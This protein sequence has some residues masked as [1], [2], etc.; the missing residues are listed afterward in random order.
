MT[1]DERRNSPLQRHP[2]PIPPTT[3]PASSIPTGWREHGRIEQAE[4][5]RVQLRLA[6][7]DA[8]ARRT[9]KHL[10]LRQQALLR[11]HGDAWLAP[12]RPYLHRTFDPPLRPE[13]RVSPSSARAS[14]RRPFVE[15][16]RFLADPAGLFAAAPNHRIRLLDLLFRAAQ[17][18]HLRRPA[19]RRARVVPEFP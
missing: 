8:L 17:S 4:F 5:I 14:S 18:P 10:E 6:G 3:R 16:D 13:A 15:P 1:P 19:S 2:P 7:I 11:K 12:L 9:A